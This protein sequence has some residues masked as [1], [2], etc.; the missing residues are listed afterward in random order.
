MLVFYIVFF[1]DYSLG[2]K[3]WN[4]NLN[5]EVQC[6]LKLSSLFYCFFLILLLLFLILCLFYFYKHTKNKDYYFFFLILILANSLVVFFKI[7][8]K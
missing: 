8:I 7:T 6:F 4:H 1:E 5:I 2:I 3:F